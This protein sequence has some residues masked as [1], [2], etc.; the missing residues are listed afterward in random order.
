VSEQPRVLTPE[1]E[2]LMEWREQIG[3][4]VMYAMTCTHKGDD[5][6]DRAV[7]VTCFANTQ[8]I[9]ALIEHHAAVAWGQGRAAERRDWEFTA[10]LSTPDKERRPL[11]N[12]YRALS[13]SKEADDAI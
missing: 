8:S 3:V 12:P 5:F 1:A 13:P 9:G 4:R 11:A 10:D 7:C 6:G 2:A